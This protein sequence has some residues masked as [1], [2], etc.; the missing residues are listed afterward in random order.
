MMN[1]NEIFA[2]K[3]SPEAI[4]NDEFY[5]VITVATVCV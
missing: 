4:F 5:A 2:T 1:I 3:L